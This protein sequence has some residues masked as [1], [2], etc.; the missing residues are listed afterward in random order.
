[1]NSGDL[2]TTTRSKIPFR[3]ESFHDKNKSTKKNMKKQSSMTTRL[4]TVKTNASNAKISRRTTGNLSTNIAAKQKA[5]TDHWRYKATGINSKN[6][7]SEK[8]RANNPMMSTIDRRMLGH[9]FPSYRHQANSKRKYIF[10]N[11]AL[12]IK[13]I[14]LKP[15]TER[16][17]EYTYKTYKANTESKKD[18]EDRMNSPLFPSLSSGFQVEPLYM[19]SPPLFSPSDEV[20]SLAFLLDGISLSPPPP[21]ELSFSSSQSPIFFS[22]SDGFLD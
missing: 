17:R 21:S 18:D 11:T 19:Y 7:F 1:M 16:L 20:N 15:R 8:P 2:K 12:E 13:P 10:S 5:M 14:K 6:R 4:P 22:P 3:A 9:S